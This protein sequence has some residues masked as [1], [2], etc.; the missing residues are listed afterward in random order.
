MGMFNN[1]VWPEAEP[2]PCGAVLSGWQTNDIGYPYLD[3]DVYEIRGDQVLPPA[4]IP[5]VYA[6]ALVYTK[7][8]ECKRWIEF[9][10]CIGGNKIDSIERKPS[11]RRSGP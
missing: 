11:E 1:V 8:S 2:C 6:R 5:A 7:C 10:F 9:E 3:L 4:E